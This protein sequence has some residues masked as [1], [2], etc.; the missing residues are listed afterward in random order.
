MQH[1]RIGGP[2]LSLPGLLLPAVHKVTE[3]SAKLDRR[4]CAL[5]CVEAIRLYAAV[6]DGQLPARLAA[7]TEVPMPDDPMT[8]RA[9][10]YELAG[11]TATLTASPPGRDQPYAFNSFKYEITIVR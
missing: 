6:H 5:R 3:A 8:G 10:Q 9:F 1:P 11:G 2:G 4:I 7:I